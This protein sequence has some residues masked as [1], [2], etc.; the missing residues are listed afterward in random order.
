MLVSV[1]TPSY[2]QGEFIEATLQSVHNQT[3]PSIEHIVVD[4]CSTDSTRAVLDRYV[5]KI[6][7]IIEPDNGQ[8]DAINKGMRCAS[9]EVMA[10][11]N[12]DDLYLPH[13]VK[14]VVDFFNSYP[15]AL[16]VYGDVEAI[17]RAGK[18]Y[19]VRPFIQQTDADELVHIR[20]RIVQPAVFWRRALWEQIGELDTTLHYVM[21]YEYW[22]RA[23]KVTQLRYT[24]VVL[25]QERLYDA[26]KT[27]RG[28]LKRIRELEEIALRHGGEGLPANFKAEAA[29]TYLLCGNFRSAFQLRPPFAKLMKHLIAQSVPSQAQVW[30]MLTRWTGK[31]RPLP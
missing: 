14:T 29:A 26:A 6:T 24:P 19:G 12:G 20:N 9:G 23:A 2:N 3:Y 22:M 30:L 5:G 8:T 16:F 17:D 31:S 10:W 25:A 13:T 11:L 15:E 1:V 28:S 18:S 7:T 27:F 21:D 4:N